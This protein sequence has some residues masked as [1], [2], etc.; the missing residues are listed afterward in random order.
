MDLKIRC[1]KRRENSVAQKILAYN[2]CSKE[3]EEKGMNYLVG[4]TDLANEVAVFMDTVRERIIQGVMRINLNEVSSSKVQCPPDEDTKEEK[5]A[6]AMVILKETSQNGFSNIRQVFIG[7]KED[8]PSVY[9]IKK[10]WS[11]FVEKEI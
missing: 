3:L 9:H 8:L 11:K 2:V 10:I 7:S 1:R 4:H 5:I 6:K